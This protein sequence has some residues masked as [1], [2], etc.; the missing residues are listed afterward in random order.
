MTA[1]TRTIL[2]YT[3][4]LEAL[5][6]NCVKIVYAH[7]K[8]HDGNVPTQRTHITA[9]KFKIPLYSGIISNIRDVEDIRLVSIMANRYFIR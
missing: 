1:T 3:S 4:K 6:R 5:F 2:E 8:S 7:A 9:L